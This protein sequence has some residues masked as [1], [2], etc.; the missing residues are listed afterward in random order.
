MST[1]TRPEL[2]ENNKFWIEKHR[3]YELKHFCLQYPIWKKAYASLDGLSKRPSDLAIFSNTKVC[4]D[5]TAKCAISKEFYAE[6]MEM[7]GRTA[8]KTDPEL[9]DY[10]LK[11][12]TEGRSYSSLKTMFDIPCSKDTYYER[13]RKFFWLLNK[14]RK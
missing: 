5:P 8:M 2:S 13:Y 12:V 9:S 3:Y 11:G 1:T 10:I 6:R 7:V 14:E 4:S